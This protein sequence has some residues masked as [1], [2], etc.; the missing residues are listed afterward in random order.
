MKLLKNLEHG[1]LLH[2]NRNNSAV[3]VSEN[4]H[5]RWLSIDHVCQ[6]IMLKRVPSKLVLPHQ[7]FMMLPLLFH[8]PDT[9]CEIGLGAGSFVRFFN[10]V[11]PD[12][13]LTSIEADKRIIDCFYQYFPNSHKHH[14]IENQMFDHNAQLA[15]HNQ[16]QWWLY[17]LYDPDLEEQGSAEALCHFLKQGSKQTIRSINITSTCEQTV[18]KSLTV[19]KQHL[20]HCSVFYFE[21]PQY[22]NVVVIALPQPPTS[23]AHSVLSTVRQKRWLQLWNN[24]IHL[25]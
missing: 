11:L 9:I 1:S 21:V 17:D 8:T 5:Y 3:S 4:E 20:S 19:I 14:I 22:S 23:T 10:S 7:Y 15:G 16:I 18:N 24:G 13:S 2:L 12:A 25:L 6:S